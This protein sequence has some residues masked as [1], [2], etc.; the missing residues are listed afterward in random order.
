MAQYIRKGPDGSDST[1]PPMPCTLNFSGRQ[2]AND[3]V[4]K[5]GYHIR[6][7]QN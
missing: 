7:L 5:R 1:M 4:G 3:R 2:E 6:V